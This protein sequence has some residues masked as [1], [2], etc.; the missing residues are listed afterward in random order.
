MNRY[1]KII[2]YGENYNINLLKCDRFVLFTDH[3]TKKYGLF[4]PP[5]KNINYRIDDKKI[6]IPQIEN[7]IIVFES[8]NYLI[9]KLN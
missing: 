9:R 3:I 8:Q 7:A 2:E 1:K 6:G 5:N 4:H